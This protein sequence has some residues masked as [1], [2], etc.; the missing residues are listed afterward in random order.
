MRF[1]LASVC[2][3]AVMACAS[4]PKRRA[5][6]ANPGP[7]FQLGPPDEA[8]VAFD[9]PGWHRT[10]GE[11]GKAEEKD[12]IQLHWNDHKGD[13]AVAIW[14]KPADPG[15]TVEAAVSRFSAMLMA[16][17]VLFSEPE[18]APVQTLSDEEAIFTFRGVDSKSRKRMV[19]Y[20]R[21]KLVSGHATAFWA[22]ILVFGPET[23]APQMTFEADALAKSLRVLPA[24]TPA[25]SPN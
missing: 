11:K 10:P 17:P 19:A 9:A 21:V 20:C 23:I 22:M 15:S 6:A 7:T 24:L 18:A 4:T 25:T 2:A 14:I 12:F 16:I 3:L 5:A 8:H 1:L 13:R